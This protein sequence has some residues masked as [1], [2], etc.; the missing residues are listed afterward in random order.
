M[1]FIV[2]DQIGKASVKPI[3]LEHL[4]KIFNRYYSDSYVFRLHE[5]SGAIKAPPSKSCMQRA[6]AAALINE[7]N[8]YY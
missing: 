8:Y 1:S 5:L 2:L 7:W 6:C 4:H 3:A